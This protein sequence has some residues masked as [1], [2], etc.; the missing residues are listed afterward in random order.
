[1][2]ASP[3]TNAKPT[4]DH[5]RTAR[6][7]GHVL[8]AG[9]DEVG[10]GS[11]AGPVVAAAVILP[12]HRRRLSEMLECVRDSKQLTATQRRDACRLIFA[13]GAV[14]SLGWASHHIVD[15]DGLAYANRRAMCRAIAGLSTSPD[16]VLL[17]HFA[18]P[19]CHLPQ[20]CI[21]HGD[22]TCL[23]IAAASIVAKVFRDDCMNRFERRFPGY[24]F[25]Q[26][27]GYGTAGHRAALATLGISPLH[28]RSFGPVAELAS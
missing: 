22:A 1:M 23:S 14:V 5:E 24:G 11:W 17:D 27:K 10:R 2:R 18:L 12:T 9:V 28:R 15:R 20:V 7:A 25:A 3:S 21:T 26:H 6:R 13:S 4:L 16:A 8:V 19:E